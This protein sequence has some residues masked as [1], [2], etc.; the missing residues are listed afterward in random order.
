[1]ESKKDA[2]VNQ[3]EKRRPTLFAL[4]SVLTKI[5]PRIAGMNMITP[6]YARPIGL[7]PA[8]VTPAQIVTTT[9]DLVEIRKV[10]STTYSLQRHP[11]IRE[12]SFEW[13]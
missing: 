11:R 7:K 4:G 8:M 2:L 9:S 10:A 6:A 3:Y 5:A 1:V 13:D 12:E